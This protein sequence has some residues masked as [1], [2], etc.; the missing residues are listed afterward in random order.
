M[1][2]IGGLSGVVMAVP[3][4]DIHIHDT[5][6]IVGHIHY[7][8]FGA[9]ILGVMG[10]IYFWYPKMF[11]R[12]MNEWFGK[13]HFALTLIFLNLTFFPMHFLGARGFPRRYAAHDHVEEFA[14]L[15]P[16]HQFITYAAFAMGVA[17][18]IFVVNFFGSLLFGKKAEKNP[19]QSNTLEWQTSSP[20]PHG[21]YDFQPIVE[22]G[23]YEYSNP[24]YEDDFWP[25]TA[26]VENEE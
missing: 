21:N 15:M 26:G 5:Y 14:E 20:P 11:G 1:F 22:R 7:V 12:Q 18:L 16:L 9:S 2:I 17:Q 23:P 19:W 8:L 25:Q 24:D 6:Y 4:V 3:P 10:A 13:L